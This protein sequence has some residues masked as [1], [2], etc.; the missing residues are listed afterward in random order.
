MVKARRDCPRCRGYVDLCH[1]GGI[2]R[3]RELFAR[4]PLIKRIPHRSLSGSCQPVLP[5]NTSSVVIWADWSATAEWRGL[6]I[7]AAVSV[8]LP[9]RVDQ[10]L[11]GPRH[12]LRPGIQHRRPGQLHAVRPGH[13]S[14]HALLKRVE[15][16]GGLVC[17]GP[18]RPRIQPHR[19]AGR[20]RHRDLQRQ[21]RHPV[22][23]G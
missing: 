16:H 10:G 20:G 1:T 17:E 19:P 4:T 14:S 6:P 11:V 13:R 9:M 8:G 21:S 15:V 22:R 3:G 23:W 5:I 12:V 18:R 2:H 7:H